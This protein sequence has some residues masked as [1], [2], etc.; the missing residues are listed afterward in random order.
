M[1]RLHSTLLALVLGAAATAALFA[2]ART[3][4]LGQKTSAEKSTHA[5]AR[6]L[7][8]RQAKLDRW[9]RSLQQ[10][11]AKRPPALP[12]LPKFAPVKA[13]SAATAASP[14]SQTAVAAQPKVSYVRRQTVVKYRHAKGASSTTTTP[15]T[16]SDD[17]ASSDD[18]AGGGPAP[19]GD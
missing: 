1:S 16:W 6:D 17:G 19:G 10:A 15:S 4:R 5:V 8:F 13:P 3:V 14:V 18:G 9:S 2:A 12:K 7:A 11:R